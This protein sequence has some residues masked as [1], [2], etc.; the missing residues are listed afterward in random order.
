MNKVK[1]ASVVLKQ[2]LLLFRCLELYG[3]LS[4]GW[5]HVCTAQS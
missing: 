5:N 4:I 1:P 3:A 2:V